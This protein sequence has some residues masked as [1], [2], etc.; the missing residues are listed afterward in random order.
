MK[1][2]NKCGKFFSADEIDNHNL[3]CSYA[4]SNEDYMNLIPCEFCDEL[5]S[6]E[7]YESHVSR[8][9]RRNFP[10]SFNQDTHEVDDVTRQ[11]Q[12]DPI[13][14]ALFRMF[15]GD[16]ITN[17]TNP[18]QDDSSSLL[19]QQQNQTQNQNISENNTTSS[20]ENGTPSVSQP[21]LSTIYDSNIDSSQNDVEI[22]YDRNIS[23]SDI[24]QDN[25]QND[26]I[27]EDQ[28]SVDNLENQNEI[29]N[30]ADNQPNISHDQQNSLGSRQFFVNINPN[31]QSNIVEGENIINILD[32]L[33][34]NLNNINLQNIPQNIGNIQINT[35]LDSFNSSFDF[36][37]YE[38]L[39]N[40]QDVEV[41]VSDIDKISEMSFEKV[42]CP[43]CC[44]ECLLSRKTKCGHLFCDGCLTEW[45]KTSKKC[46]SCMV[47][48]E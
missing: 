4:F 1:K 5:I 27:E 36:E 37:N 43:I 35:D 38:E 48:L 46:P 3:V 21:N 10:L 8:C 13:A 12:N 40:L 28:I 9:S 44:N 2:C 33:I 30:Q 19:S 34:N 18:S 17:T 25:S 29:P 20:I 39:S 11:I 16:N 15:I 47:E 23:E 14:R 31:N 45:L 26:N 7:D 32:S 41:G 6:I 22:V 42:E 24:D